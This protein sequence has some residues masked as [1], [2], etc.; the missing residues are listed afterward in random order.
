MHVGNQVNITSVC[1]EELNIRKISIYI[2]GL[3]PLLWYIKITWPAYNY[4]RLN[5]DPKN[6]T[7][8][9]KDYVSKNEQTTK[10]MT[11]NSFPT[12]LMP[13]FKPNPYS[14]TFNPL[15]NMGKI[16][17]AQIPILSLTLCSNS[18]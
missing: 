7:L 1:K 14:R 4:K 9:V 13:C 12:P 3:C 10:F 8:A 17:T 18:S 6:P 16:V 15:C 2:I 11:Y 5:P